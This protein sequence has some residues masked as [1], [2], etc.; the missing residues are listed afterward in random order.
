MRAE[1]FQ[2][3][4]TLCNS[5]DHSPRGS[6][7]HGASRK[8]TGVGCHTFLQEI[9]LTQGLNPSLLY[10]LHCVCVCVYKCIYTKDAENAFY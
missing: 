1:S 9:F 6:S 10:L 3:C 4:L 2:L 5:V 8:N 7:I